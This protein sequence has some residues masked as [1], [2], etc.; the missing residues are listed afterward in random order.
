MEERP[1]KGNCDKC[2]A[3]YLEGDLFCGVCGRA[4]PYPPDSNPAGSTPPSGTA[5]N[6][7]ASNRVPPA[8]ARPAPG[9][10]APV[11][12]PAVPP[13]PRPG[14]VPPAQG[15]GQ[16]GPVYPAP[17]AGYG[18]P[19]HPGFPPQKPKKGKGALAAIIALAC[20]VVLLLAVLLF[21]MLGKGTEK[22]E[23]PP[24]SPVVSSMPESSVPSSEA[25]SSSQA[26][27]SVP[28]SEAPQS[29]RAESPEPTPSETE[30]S[31][32]EAAPSNYYILPES[33][34]RL[35]TY[36][37][38]ENFTEQDLM[39]ARNEI[40][41]RHG[42]KFQDEDVRTYF[43]AQSWYRG[44]I[45]AENFSESLLSEIERKNVEFL[46]KYEAG[47]N[48]VEQKSGSL[49]V[50]TYGG[51]ILPQSSSRLLT[52]SDL[53]PLSGRQLELARNEIYA[54]HGRRFSDSE[55]QAYFDAQ[56]WYR[57]TVSPETFDASVLSGVEQSNIELIQ[58][59]E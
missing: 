20:V 25:L 40:Y 32:P 39:L 11:F 10:T 6:G 58:S 36:R 42:R 13:A 31:L 29:S 28:S 55:I 12:M 33:S 45:E 7:T 22:P 3:P 9:Q 50:Y 47:E 35:L 49:V 24:S 41:A 27:S 2:G 19:A 46:H 30:P 8:P 4:V 53:A 54:R 1:V 43:E 38:V 14:A 52:A 23:T 57:G 51:Y 34:K 44:E 56:S 17:P 21:L 5:P 37:D 26:E 15:A 16:S 48:G 59:Y 18:G